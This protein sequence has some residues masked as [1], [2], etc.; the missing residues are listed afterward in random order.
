MK[1]IRI[2]FEQ[3]AALD[4]IEIA[5]RAA[6]IDAEVQKLLG[7]L[8]ANVD[9]T[10]TVTDE[11]GAV[12]PI[13][14]SRIVSISV[15]GRQTDV[16]TEDGRYL[17]R[18]SL[19]NIENVLDP[20]QFVRISRYEIINLSKV[21]RFD[22]TLIGTLRLELYGGME[23]WASRRSIPAIRRHLQGKE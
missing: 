21:R 14:V 3:D 10:L 15:L 11:T 6:E 18:Q 4:G 7:E 9:N 1:T 16:V 22:F 19:N 8:T 2:R 5:V 23:T 12:L 20:R 13:P 17:S